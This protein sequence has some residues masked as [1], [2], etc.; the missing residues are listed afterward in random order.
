MTNSISN[1]EQPEGHEVAKMASK[2]GLP[3]DSGRRSVSSLPVSVY[4]IH[5]L[6]FRTHHS[7][8]MILLSILLVI[9]VS[10]CSKPACSLFVNRGF[11][12]VKKSFAVLGV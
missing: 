10:Y 3:S 8:A 2:K 5:L 9:Y 1:G 12:L 7:Y 6:Q 4:L 11:V